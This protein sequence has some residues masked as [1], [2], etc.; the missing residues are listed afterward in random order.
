MAKE[1]LNVKEVN[2]VTGSE[3]GGSPNPTAEINFEITLE[4]KREGLMR[5]IV[6]QVQ[7]T[8]KIAKL[9]VDDKISLSFLTSDE[10]LNAVVNDY[11]DTIAAETLASEI[12]EDEYENRQILKIDGAEL[13]VT[14]QK[15]S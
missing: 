12:T 2:V 4:L 14:L 7:S 15:V 1:E 10:L 6:H 13:L 3:I 9:K 11:R 5:E 8:R